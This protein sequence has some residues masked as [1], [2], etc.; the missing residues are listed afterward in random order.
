MKIS[1]RD[2]DTTFYGLRPPTTTDR[3]GTSDDYAHHTIV[4]VK[5]EIH[6]AATVSSRVTERHAQGSTPVSSARSTDTTANLQRAIIA[7]F[8]IVSIGLLALVG[9]LPIEPPLWYTLA[10]SG[11]ALVQVVIGAWMIVTYRRQGVWA[12]RLAPGSTPP[13]GR[14]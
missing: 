14:G 1:Y 4:E 7:F 12:R 6:R 8:A 2:D 5:V 11:I 13:E 9:V 3:I 10:R